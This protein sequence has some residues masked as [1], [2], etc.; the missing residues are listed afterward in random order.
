[1][2]KGNKSLPIVLITNSGNKYRL[3]MADVNYGIAICQEGYDKN[4]LQNLKLAS[5][6][7]AQKQKDIL[8]E[9]NMLTFEQKE[10]LFSDDI[11]NT[12]ITKKDRADED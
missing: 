8:D 2:Y 5:E 7:V 1:M 9:I 3:V 11:L 10:Q 6:I 4:R 12:T